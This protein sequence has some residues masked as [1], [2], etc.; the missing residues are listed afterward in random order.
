M[1]TLQTETRTP[2]PALVNSLRGR[3]VIPYLLIL[4]TGVLGALGIGVFTWAALDPGALR[5]GAAVGLFLG[6]LGEFIWQ[7]IEGPL[8]YETVISYPQAEPAEQSSVS[9]PPREPIIVTTYAK[10]KAMAED[11]GRKRAFLETCRGLKRPSF[12]TLGAA[13]WIDKTE[14]ARFRDE[15][16]ADGKLRWKNEE[17]GTFEN[18]VSVSKT[19]SEGKSE[20]GSQ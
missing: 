5:V 9:V 18:V 10:P 8:L 1:P 14:V 3:V 4:G 7:R 11:G 17:T 15:W 2:I 6:I 16:I 12:N 13:G 20:R 19:V